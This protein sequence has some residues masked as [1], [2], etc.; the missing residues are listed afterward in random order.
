[1]M[2]Y[3]IFFY[4]NALFWFHTLHCKWLHYDKITNFTY[5]TTRVV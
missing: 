5:Y 1:M 4:S 2:A 3:K